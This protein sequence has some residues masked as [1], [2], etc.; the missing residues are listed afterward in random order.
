[1]MATTGGNVNYDIQ[2]D[3]L[4]KTV[5]RGEINEEEYFCLVLSLLG[6]LQTKFSFI[7]LVENVKRSNRRLHGKLLDLYATRFPE[8]STGQTLI[9]NSILDEDLQLEL[10]LQLSIKETSLPIENADTK[11]LSS[12]SSVVRSQ[13]DN[14]RNSD[15]DRVDRDRHG[16]VVQEIAKSTKEPKKRTKRKGR[17]ERPL[18][19]K[20]VILWFRRDLRIFDNPALI[21][22]C[23]TERPVIPIF[24]WS[25]IEEGPLAA[26]GATKIWLHHAL[27]NLSN[28]LKNRYNSQLLFFRT[29]SCK[30]ELMSLVQHVDA[31][32]VIWNDLAEPWL[33]RRDDSMCESLERI[34][35]NVRR[36]QSYCLYD[37][38]SVRTD[39]VGMRGIGSVSHF[40]ACSK[41]TKPDRS[42]PLP[43]DPPSSMLLTGQL[44]HSHTLDELDL[45]RMPKKK[46]GSIVS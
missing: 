14:A 35:V 27:K 39:S 38:Y 36:F 32:M 44:L 5:I 12:W 21:E 33:R 10:A 15:A 24:L 20:P 43:M 11:P 30:K 26:G 18:I 13:S 16:I 40:I 29:K 1:M 3:D 17:I 25:E 42:I 9:S 4:T 28:C 8:K 19:Q 34:A 23:R 6:D 45:N 41:S 46:D 7:K 2:L 22:A 31:S 37:P